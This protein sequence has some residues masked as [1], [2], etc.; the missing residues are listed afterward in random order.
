MVY[1]SKKQ[2]RQIGAREPEVRERG[3]PG[4]AAAVPQMRML[5]QASPAV[6]PTSSGSKAGLALRHLVYF[7]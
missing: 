1:S 7:S 5:L 3:E 4:A 2:C 6:G